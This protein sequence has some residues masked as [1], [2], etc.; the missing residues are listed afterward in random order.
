[1]S[2]CIAEKV[3]CAGCKE[4]VFCSAGCRDTYNL[5]TCHSKLECKVLKRI[6]NP[7]IK[8]TTDEISFVRLVIRI[9]CRR[10]EASALQQQQNSDSEQE[11]YSE[12]KQLIANVE[13]LEQKDRVTCQRYRDIADFV[14]NLFAKNSTSPDEV[15]ELLCQI[16]CNAFGIWNK[17]LENARGTSFNFS[18]NN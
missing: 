6:H 8:L 15:M 16:E 3:F 4:V 12:L 17:K 1:M 10:L 5:V 14:S 7:K 11:F 9:I 13:L 2:S 18:M